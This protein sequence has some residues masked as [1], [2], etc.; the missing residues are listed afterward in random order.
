MTAAGLPTEY[1]PPAWTRRFPDRRLWAGRLRLWRVELA[2]R[3]P[4]SPLTEWIVR[5]AT[6]RLGLPASAVASATRPTR[7]TFAFLDLPTGLKLVSDPSR[8]F[9]PWPEPIAA[10]PP[11]VLHPPGVDV[12]PLSANWRTVPVVRAEAVEV[13]AAWQDERIEVYEAD[14]PDGKPLWEFPAEAMAGVD[15]GR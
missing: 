5:A 6:R 3:P 7:Q 14:E 8:S 13:V 15:V 12:V 10:V 9:D 2:V 4:S 11:A 1:I